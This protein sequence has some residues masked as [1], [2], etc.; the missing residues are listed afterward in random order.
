[1]TSGPLTDRFPFVV[2]EHSLGQ[3]HV[4]MGWFSQLLQREMRQS[5]HKR[6]SEEGE[7]KERNGEGRK[8]K[9]EESIAPSPGHG[10]FSFLNFVRM[11][12]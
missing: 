6:W 9:G 5:G 2:S 3:F 10:N 12:S 4:E 8:G 1:M 7:R 11:K